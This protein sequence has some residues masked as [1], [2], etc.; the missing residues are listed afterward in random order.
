[1]EKIGGFFMSIDKEA[2]RKFIKENNIKSKD[3]FNELMQ[4]ITKTVVET[5]LDEELTEHLGYSKH[6]T[7]SKKISNSRNGYSPKKVNSKHGEFDLEVPRD[8][9]SDFVP[10]IIEK[11]KKDLT[12]IEDKII[13]MYARG[14]TVR[15]IQAHIYEIYSYDISSETVSN[16]TDSVLEK[17][18]DW[19]N[20]P[21][22]PI[23]PICFLD[24][25]FLKM[26]KEGRI[27][28]IAVYAIIAINTAGCKECL[29]LW[30]S[31]SES[32]KFWL[33]VLNDLKNRGVKDIL[34]FSVDNLPGISEAIQ[35]VFPEAEIQKCIVHQIRN[36]LKFVVWKDRKELARD[37]KKIYTSIT[38]E[39]ALVELDDFKEKWDKKYP[40]I[41]M[42]WE[43]NWGELATFFKYPQE[44]RTIIY[45]TNPIESVNRGIKKV[46]KNRSVF[47][48]EQAI[49]K[50][51]YLAIE[52]ISKKWIQNIRNWGMIYA[53]LSIFFEERL[54]RYK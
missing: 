21:L 39:K 14:M 36:S 1:M 47:P 42:S 22:D 29:G 31:E 20:R 27:I 17:A 15:D 28:N 51:L 19:Q 13:S 26:R 7:K 43:K 23:Y 33:K 34:I 54:S 46:S 16:I 35:A 2:L 44:I 5:M 38:E 8:R 48:N 41:A 10:K 52:N 12:G 24:A 49:F 37:L 32:A 6:D 3:D 9:D 25:T 18:Q 11:R 50:L 45:T 4:S 53:Q 30:I 40:N